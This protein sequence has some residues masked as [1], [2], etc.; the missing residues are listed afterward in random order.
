MSGVVSGDEARRL[1][2]QHPEAFNFTPPPAET[3]PESSGAIMELLAA[4]ALRPDMVGRAAE[5]I[6]KGVQ[7]VKSVF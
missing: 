5:F 3:R 1:W 2:V 6:A 4:T 7:T